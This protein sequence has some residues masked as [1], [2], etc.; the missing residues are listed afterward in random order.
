[1]FNTEAETPNKAL[2]RSPAPELQVAITPL[3]MRQARFDSA[4]R[5]FD[6][7]A[8]S[9]YLE[10]ASEGFEQALR[11]NERLR[12]EIGRVGS[13]LA[14]YRE[15]E[16]GIKNTMLTAQKVADDLRENAV[17]ESARIVREAEGRAELIVQKARARIEDV[18]REI[19]SLRLKRRE[20]EVSL[21]AIVA[22]LQSAL[23]F[24]RE[25]DGRDSHRGRAIA[26]VA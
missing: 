25:Q 22:T 7:T 20:A 19:S 1:M 10:T 2:T 26:E 9:A 16:S 13:A 8:V 17:Q 11:E 14:Q 12:Q 6:K 4:M 21:N 5:G 18:E 15:L 23:D 24:V 3:D